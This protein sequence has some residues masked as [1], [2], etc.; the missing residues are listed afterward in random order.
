MLG[1]VLSA[2]GLTVLCV[3]SQWCRDAKQTPPV[4]NGNQHKTGNQKRAGQ[5]R[6]AGARQVEGWPRL[7]L[8]P[9]LV[10]G[11]DTLPSAWLSKPGVP[12]LCGCSDGASVCP[13]RGG[14]S[15][16][17]SNNGVS[18]QG[19]GVRV[20]QQWW[21]L[22]LTQQLCLPPFLPPSPTAP[23]TPGLAGKPRASEVPV[24]HSDLTRD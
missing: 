4:M 1:S 7:S 14:V 10:V 23:F 15:A 19:W 5:Q 12:I 20:S 24:L 11:W 2:V 21:V 17:P 16:C 22:A 9:A 6:E 13:S 18:Q 8:F 3:P